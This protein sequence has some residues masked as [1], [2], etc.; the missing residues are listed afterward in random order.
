MAKVLIYLCD[1]ENL[2]FVL[3]ILFSPCYITKSKNPDNKQL[4]IINTI[5]YI[6]TPKINL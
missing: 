2:R 1:V 3:L 5:K 4:Y 6:D